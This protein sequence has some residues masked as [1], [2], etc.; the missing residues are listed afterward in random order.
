M[1]LSRKAALLLSIALLGE[2]HMRDMFSWLTPKNLRGYRSSSNFLN[3][4]RATT[5]TRSLQDDTKI[6]PLLPHA[7][8]EDNKNTKQ[9]HTDHDYH[10][11][12]KDYQI[13][14]DTLS[15]ETQPDG[16]PT[17]V[18]ETVSESLNCLRQDA[19]WWFENSELPRAGTKAGPGGLLNQINGHGDDGVLCDPRYHL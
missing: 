16:W 13:I 9:L 19:R 4:V 6:E 12:E 14:L 1:N 5:K 7:N 2:R 11:S 3:V 15:R 10:R 8:Y 17:L 18:V